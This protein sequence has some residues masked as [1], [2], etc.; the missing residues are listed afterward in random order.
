MAK[1][2]IT[3]ETVTPESAEQGD[4]ADRGY[5]MDGGFHVD[6]ETDA[7]RDA[8]AYDLRGALSHLSGLE[9]CGRWFSEV[10]DRI[11]YQTGETERRSLHPPS[12]ITPA[13]YRRLKRLL[14]AK[15]LL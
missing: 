15:R 8:A 9:D 12:T 2:H 14:Q 3:Y 7:D 1:F 11:D 10:D 6:V 5:I 13:S 4:A